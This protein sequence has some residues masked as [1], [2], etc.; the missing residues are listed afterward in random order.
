MTDVDESTILNSRFQKILQPFKEK[1]SVQVTSILFVIILLLIPVYSYL[2]AP[3]EDEYQ[4]DIEY[5]IDGDSGVVTWVAQTTVELGDGEV[6]SLAF[7]EQDFPEEAKSRNII[8][9]DFSV[10]VVDSGEDNEETN[11][12]GC[13]ADSGEAAP[14]SVSVFVNTPGGSLTMETQTST[15]DW[16]E[17]MEYP[18][19]DTYP[20]ITGYTVAEIEA[21]FDTSEEVVGEYVFEYTG[22]VESGDSTFQCERQD[23]SVTIEY[24]I[25]LWW[26][27]AKVVEWNGDFLF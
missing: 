2:N 8:S 11:G 4:R 13:A 3:P 19:F 7:T 24:L 9:V 6:F 22:G 26:Y 10:S 5:I 12:L 14:D 18:E 20:F 25:D 15:Y 16:I 23:S 27:D 17:L 21:M 1:R